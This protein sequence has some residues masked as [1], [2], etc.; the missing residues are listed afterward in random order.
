R[1]GVFDEASS[2]A[3]CAS[4]NQLDEEGCWA[5]ATCSRPWLFGAAWRCAWLM[6]GDAWE[7]Q[8]WTSP[9]CCCCC[10]SLGHDEAFIDVE[11]CATSFLWAGRCV[12]LQAFKKNLGV[13][14]VAG[15]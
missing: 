5:A 4:T 2:L 9:S 11:S 6:H 7:L 1:F 10:S 13:R 12:Q 8:S 15:P 3:G 14:E